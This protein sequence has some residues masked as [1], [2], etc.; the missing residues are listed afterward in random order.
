VLI[1]VIIKKS[2]SNIFLPP[3]LPPSFPPFLPSFLL[4]VQLFS[5]PC[6]DT[7]NV[8]LGALDNMFERQIWPLAYV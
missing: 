5:I 1:D 6:S 3:S 7:D 2:K 4:A 8:I